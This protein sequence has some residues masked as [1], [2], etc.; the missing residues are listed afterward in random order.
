MFSK[1]RLTACH[2]RTYPILQAI[3]GILST[4]LYN[5]NSDRDICPRDTKAATFSRRKNRK[6]M[7][8]RM[9]NIFRLVITSDVHFVEDA[10][11][12]TKQ[13][14]RMPCAM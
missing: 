7:H 6:C 12:S 14:R 5:R 11:C 8:P 4:S 9:H 3:T 10:Q 1:W 13:R 2:A